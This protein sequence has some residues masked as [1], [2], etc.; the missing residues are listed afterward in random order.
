[1]ASKPLP[2]EKVMN[3][4]DTKQNLSKVVTEVARGESYVI[5][6]KSGLESAAIIH[7]EEFR[8]F[9]RYSEEQRV[10]RARFFERLALLGDAFEDVSDEELERELQRAQAEVK[11][12]MANE[13]RST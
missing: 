7:P 2:E 6:E 13:R 9:K 10:K 5:V 3:L 4:T 1:M 8:R 11:D 12:E